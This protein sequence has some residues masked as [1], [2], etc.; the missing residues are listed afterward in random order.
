MGHSK[1]QLVRSRLQSWF[2]LYVE[3]AARLILIL[4]AIISRL[5]AVVVSVALLQAK[6]LLHVSQILERA[7]ELV[8]EAA[9]LDIL[10]QATITPPIAA[11]IAVTQPTIMPLPA[12]QTAFL[13]ANAVCLAS[14]VCAHPV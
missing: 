5:F 14:P 1:M 10:P 12:E 2:L 13:A 9:P 7:L 8:G 11:A 3:G 6:M 4:L